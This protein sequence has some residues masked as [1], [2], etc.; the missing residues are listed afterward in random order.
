[1]YYPY[2]LQLL[3]DLVNSAFHYSVFFVPIQLMAK[4]VQSAFWDV[5]AIWM[6]RLSPH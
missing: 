1:M 5:R 4:P 2:V 6:Q 3:Q